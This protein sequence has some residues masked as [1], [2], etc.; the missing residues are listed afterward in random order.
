MAK[1]LTVEGER[2]EQNADADET[3]DGYCWG[4]VEAI[5]ISIYKRQ[6]RYLSQWEKTT[7]RCVNSKSPAND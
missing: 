1:A 5:G 6:V 7:S 2:K 3:L 4:N